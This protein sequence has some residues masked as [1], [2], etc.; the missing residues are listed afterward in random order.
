MG[1]RRKRNTTPTVA[2]AML[3]AAIGGC[4]DDTLRT[5]PE[6]PPAWT[7]TCEPANNDFEP[8]PENNPDTAV[9]ESLEGRVINRWGSE[10]VRHAMHRIV[11]AD[12]EEGIPAGELQQRECLLAQT[13]YKAGE[14]RCAGDGT[15]SAVNGMIFD[16]TDFDTVV[17]DVERDE[18]GNQ[19]GNF[20]GGG[21]RPETAFDHG[22]FELPL[23]AV[24]NWNDIPI[25]VTLS[26]MVGA[27]PPSNIPDGTTPSLPDD[28]TRRYAG[29]YSADIDGNGEPDVVFEDD[30]GNTLTKAPWFGTMF[31]MVNTDG[32][33]GTVIGDWCLK[34][35]SHA[36]TFAEHLDENGCAVPPPPEETA[37]E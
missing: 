2:G 28:G 35:T 11:Q 8:K 4:N 31:D 20:P 19:L 22:R 12:A 10:A 37:V 21:C 26:F 13:F 9:N 17:I 18:F 16:G 34:S 3:A 15:T 7:E 36:D 33:R 27:Q 6:P 14:Q 5:I 25:M 29:E 32:E 1:E 23:V 24:N 30:W